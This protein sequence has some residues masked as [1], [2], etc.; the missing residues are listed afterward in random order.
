MPTSGGTKTKNFPFHFLPAPPTPPAEKGV[1]RKNFGFWYTRPE[2]ACE[3]RIV[4]FTTQSERTIQF[5][6][7]ARSARTKSGVLLEMSSN[8]LV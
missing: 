5:Q 4:R 1:V 7:T 6:A 2:G 8:F 3:A